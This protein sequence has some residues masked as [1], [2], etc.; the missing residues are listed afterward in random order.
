VTTPDK[1]K[2]GA[3]EKLRLDLMEKHP[4]APECSLVALFQNIARERPEVLRA[5]LGQLMKP[6]SVQ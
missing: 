1:S 6:S 5:L 4:G 3:A 2:M